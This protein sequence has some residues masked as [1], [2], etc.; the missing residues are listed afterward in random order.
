MPPSKLSCKQAEHKLI[1]ETCQRYIKH[2]YHEANHISLP[3]IKRQS[4]AETSG[5]ILFPSLSKVIALLTLHEEDIFI[6]LGSGMGK[7][8]IQF[9][10]QTQIKKAFGIEIMSNQYQYSVMMANRLKADLPEFYLNGRELQFFLGNFLEIP[11]TTATVILIGSPC[12]TPNMLDTLGSI[13]NSTPN[14]HTVVS[15]R[16][17]LTLSRLTF[18][19]MLS[20]ECTWDTAQAYIYSDH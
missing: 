14:I 12:F 7:A 4:I 20:L 15:L 18:R 11:F 2:L 3:Q 19:R 6:D 17:L 8:V 5:E 10:L 1:N 13:I 16:P 9:F